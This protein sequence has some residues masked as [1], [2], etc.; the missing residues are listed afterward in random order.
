MTDCAAFRCRPARLR[1]RCVTGGPELVDPTLIGSRGNTVKVAW[2]DLG[3]AERIAVPLSRHGGHCSRMDRFSGRRGGSPPSARARS[4]QPCVAL[5]GEKIAAD[6]ARLPRFRQGV[7]LPLSFR[8]RRFR[9]TARCPV[10]AVT[11][12]FECSV[13]SFLLACRWSVDCCGGATAQQWNEPTRKRESPRSL[14]P[15]RQE[16]AP[17][18]RAEAAAARSCRYSYSER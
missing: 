8:R 3:R 5:V 12:T 6:G 11:E 16:K 13:A 10:P 4:V 17:V 2:Y 7:S 9:R 1:R 15:A 14:Q 18:T